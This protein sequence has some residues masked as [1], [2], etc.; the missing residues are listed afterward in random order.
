MLRDLQVTRVPGFCEIIRADPSW[1]LL[2]IGHDEH[3][4]DGAGRSLQTGS[5]PEGFADLCA[6][7]ET[8]LSGSGWGYLGIISGRSGAPDLGGGGT[9]TRPGICLP[10][11]PRQE[12]AVPSAGGT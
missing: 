8:G 6:L 12:H 10:S 4:A 2:E 9:T 7:V 11:G 3:C 1:N 5:A